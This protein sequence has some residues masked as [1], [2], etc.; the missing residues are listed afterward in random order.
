[1]ATARDYIRVAATLR[2]VRSGYAAHWDPN[3]FRACDDI[4]HALAKT[5]KLENPKFKPALFL[6]AAGVPKTSQR[7]TT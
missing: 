2:E 4:A 3:L 5:F 6:D 7:E 1:M